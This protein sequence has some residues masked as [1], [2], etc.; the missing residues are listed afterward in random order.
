MRVAKE[1]DFWRLQDEC[2]DCNNVLDAVANADKEDDLMDLL[3][4]VFYDNIPTMTEIN[5]LLRFD[6]E[7]V[8]ETLG[9]D[10]ENEQDDYDED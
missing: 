6:G 4:E 8:L 5:D 1:L 2:W 7:W 3:E 10:S 9:I